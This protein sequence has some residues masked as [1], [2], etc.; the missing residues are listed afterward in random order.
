MNDIS[1][2]KDSPQIGRDSQ[3][4]I[5]GVGNMGGAIA[6]SILRG[7][8]A[9]H[10]FD[11]SPTAVADLVALGGTAADSLA[12]LAA[13]CDLISVVVVSDDQVK[14]VGTTIIANA[15][16]GTAVLV[17]STV[18]AS[19]VVDL[20]IEAAKKGVH[21]LDV[22][23]NGGQEKASRG[24]LTLMV[25]GDEATAQRLWPLLE[26]F[27]E[28]IFYMGPTGSGVVAKL[29]NN[30]IAL[31]SYSLQIEGMRLGAAYG[32]SED[33]ITTAVIASQGDNKGIR[34]WGRHDRKRAIR[35]AQGV[36][37]SERMGRDLQEAAIAAGERDVTLSITA[38]IADA[39]P[40]ILRRRDRELAA[41]DPRPE[42]KFCSVCGQDLAS[43]FRDA[44]IHP[45]C[46]PGY[47]HT[48]A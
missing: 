1:T 7:G 34:T 30:L 28:S 41:G 36:D 39:M 40:S 12:E 21:V 13:S 9:L 6:R 25:G 37:W 47:W 16:P 31:G 14:E 38:V 26:S 22:S 33:A 42:P 35:A 11:L 29:I 27:G 15:R 17:H 46:R 18:R 8:F 45:E 4:G 23:V 44:G 20:E 43:M 3:I 2:T 32:L 24:T 5:V 48:E 10:V 19:T